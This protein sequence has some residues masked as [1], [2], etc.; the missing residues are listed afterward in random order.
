MT[1]R[2]ENANKNFVSKTKTK[3]LSNMSKDGIHLV[4]GTLRLKTRKSRDVFF[5]VFSSCL[6]VVS[7]P[8]EICSALAHTSPHA[9]ARS[10]ARVQSTGDARVSC[11]TRGVSP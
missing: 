7:L 11:L 10:R 8:R 6:K 5:A 1:R 3:T 9:T 4:F 2:D